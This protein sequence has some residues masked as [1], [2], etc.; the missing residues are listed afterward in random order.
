MPV[1]WE[2]GQRLE[3][4][5]P[6]IEFSTYQSWGEIGAAIGKLREECAMATPELSAL[7]AEIIRDCPAPAD[8]TRELARWVRDN[9][10]YLSTRHGAYGYRPHPPQLVLDKRYGNC[11]DVSQLLHVMLREAGI[12]SGLVFLNTDDVAQ[13][14]R[15]VPSPL[16][17]DS[18]RRTR[19]A[20]NVDGPHRHLDAVGPVA[21]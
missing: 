8:K 18:A 17:N 20:A 3:A 1:Y 5:Q 10:R 6:G 11:N 4:D 19:R 2:E 12:D 9:V 14:C 7:V 15:E 21:Q 16:A 13:I